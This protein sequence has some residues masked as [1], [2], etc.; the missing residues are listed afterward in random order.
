MFEALDIEAKYVVGNAG[1]PHAWNLV[2]VDEQW[3][4]LDITWND[5]VPDQGE[6]VHYQYFLISDEKLSNDHEWIKSDYP[7]TAVND[8]L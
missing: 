8:Y 1:G 3:Y 7:K 4:H 6:R 5:P 2:K